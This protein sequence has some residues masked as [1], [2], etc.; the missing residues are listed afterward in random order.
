MTFDSA[1][2][3]VVD[4]EGGYVND[5]ADRGLKTKFGI[6]QRA[7]PTLD[8]AALTLADAR[9]IYRRDYWERCRCDAMPPVLA[10]AVFDLAV[11][12]GR[13]AAVKDLQLALGV[14][15]DGV[16]GPRTMAALAACDVLLTAVKVHAC[17]LDRRTN[18]PTWPQHGRGWARRVARNLLEL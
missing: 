13:H 10:F 17:G 11:N 18:A 12:A 7:Y 14:D 9:A 15:S 4:H 1:F 2:A 16:L 8:I 6:S 3:R 5:P